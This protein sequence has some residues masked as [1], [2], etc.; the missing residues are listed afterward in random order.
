MKRSVTINGITGLCITKLDVLDGVEEIK[1]GVGYRYEG[2]FLDVLPYGAHAAAEAEPVLEEM[3]G[4][5][6]SPV[7]ITEYDKL[8]VNAR[9]YIERIA[10][11]CDV[12]IVLVY[13]DRKIVVEGKGVSVLVDFGGRCILYKK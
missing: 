12:G 7:G 5:M 4:W 11:V 10:E 6:E 2:Q 9:R 1:I 3:A 13:T 8:P